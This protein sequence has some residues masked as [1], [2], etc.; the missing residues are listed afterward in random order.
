MVFGEADESS[1]RRSA[2]GSRWLLCGMLFGS[3][4][5]DGRQLVMDTE[6]KS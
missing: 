1:E 5:D 3:L 2:D 6:L 4:R